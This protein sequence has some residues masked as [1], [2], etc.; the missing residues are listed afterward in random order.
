[1]LNQCT[2]FLIVNKIKRNIKNKTLKQIK[3]L[4]RSSK[5]YKIT[6]LMKSF[7]MLRET[8]L[9]TLKRKREIE[10]TREKINR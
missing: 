5:S 4:Q 2:P 7:P 3:K 6:I 1:M 9:K 8:S 10:V